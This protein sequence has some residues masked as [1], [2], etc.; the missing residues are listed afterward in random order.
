MAEQRWELD[1][2]DTITREL[3][4]S[5]FQVA[6]DS[7]PPTVAR[8]LL[9]APDAL[10]YQFICVAHP[11][12]HVPTAA[13]APSSTDESHARFTAQLYLGRNGRYAE[14]EKLTATGIIGNER[15]L[16]QFQIPASPESLTQLRLDP[17]DRPGFLH[18]Y[19]LTLRDQAQQPL[20]RWQADATTRS[21][22]ATAP[23][24]QIA[25]QA[26]MPP[27]SGASLLLLAGTDPWLELPIPAEAF[28]EDD[29]TPTS[30][31]VEPG[32]ADVGGLPGACRH[33]TAFG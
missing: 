33:R 31:D 17:A 14:E 22:L 28:T 21:L 8:H 24:S 32:L 13:H 1:A 27:A 16:V 29:R 3:P 18:L 6:F 2:V 20:W 26:P 15:Q 10:T 9:S 11:V 30:L 12:A 7:L 5:E 19:S 25:W 23:H 4:E